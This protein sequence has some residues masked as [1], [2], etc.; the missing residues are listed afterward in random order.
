M[1]SQLCLVT[2]PHAPR[3]TAQSTTLHPHRSLAVIGSA[4]GSLFCMVPSCPS[5]TS[6]TAETPRNKLSI[7]A[8]IFCAGYLLV[9]NLCIS[10]A[11][12]AETCKSMRG[13]AC[14]QG[15]VYTAYG[16]FCISLIPRIKHLDTAAHSGGFPQSIAGSW[17]GDIM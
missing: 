13:W 15:C 6:P 17:W 2:T 14:L 1:H 12:S 3:P 11:V 9:H 7:L 10:G 5:H 16:A 4:V 8:D